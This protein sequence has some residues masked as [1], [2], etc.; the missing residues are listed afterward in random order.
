MCTAFGKDAY[1]D[2]NVDDCVVLHFAGTPKPWKAQNHINK[3]FADKWNQ[4]YNLTEYTKKHLKKPHK[5]ALI[6]TQ[7]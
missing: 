5:L 2:L 1:N 3:K 7:K 4:Y 6:P